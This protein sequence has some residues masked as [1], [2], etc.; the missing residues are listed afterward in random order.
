MGLSAGLITQPILSVIGVVGVTTIAVSAYMILYNHELY[1]FLRNTA[2][3]R[4]FRSAQHE[5]S[6]P[7]RARLRDHVIVLG[8]NDLGLQVARRLHE[9]G[10]T[11]L[12]IDTDGEK[13]RGLACHTLVGDVDYAS[14]LEEAGLH[15]ARAAIS[16]LRIENVNKLFVFQCRKAGV[17]VAVYA[18]DKSMRE[19]LIEVGVSYLVEARHSAGKRIFEELSR[20]EG[21]AP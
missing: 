15:A 12:A 3:L 19:Q 7:P 10:E 5:D 6:E 4:M 20:L 16:A 14:T 17:P 9:R 18:S 8:M 11:V 2:V 21:G 13:M 1:A